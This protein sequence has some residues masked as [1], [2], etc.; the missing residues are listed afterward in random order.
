MIEESARDWFEGATAFALDIFEKIP[1]SK[2][3]EPGLGEWTVRELAAHTIRAW[4]T[5]LSYLDEALSADEPIPAETY[6]AQALTGPDVHVGVMLRGR[7]DARSLADPSAT[8]KSI[9]R[10]ALQR[11]A[12]ETND[13]LVPSRFGPLPLPEYLRTRAFELTVHG[14]D[15]ARAAGV[16]IPASA[17][18]HIHAATK[19]AIEVAAARQLSLPALLALTGRESLPEGFTVLDSFQD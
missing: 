6:F 11:V 14:L 13:R 5:T 16:D 7:D 18:Q 2:W 15:L 17:A 9:A 12:N 8:A 3:E 4:R 1:D 10:E 19:L